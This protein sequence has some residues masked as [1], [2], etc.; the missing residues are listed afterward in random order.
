MALYSTKKVH[1]KELSDGSVIAFRV[2]VQKN[3]IAATAATARIQAQA[4]IGLT[5]GMTD[6]EAAWTRK[7][8]A[9]SSPTPAPPPA[10]ARKAAK[11]AEPPSWSDRMWQ[12]FDRTHWPTLAAECLVS[13]ERDG[14]P[15]VDDLTAA[16]IEVVPLALVEEAARAIFAERVA[17]PEIRGN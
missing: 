2:P 1:E 17:R 16:E 8:L 4:E 6:E 10:P 11:A 13:W 12:A 3:I 9:E 5:E 15:M 7:K 14:E